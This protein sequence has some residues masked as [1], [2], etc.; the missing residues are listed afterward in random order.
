[1]KP[2]KVFKYLFNLKE[3]FCLIK[4]KPEG[5]ILN[6]IVSPGKDG[7]KAV[8]DW[9]TEILKVRTKSLPFKGRANQEIEKELKKLFNAETK[10][11]TG[12]KSKKKTVLVKQDKE[13]I[14][15][16]LNAL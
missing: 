2:E 5:V 7:F 15:S 11:L 12:F 13:K 1:M 6:L 16:A 3:F 4:F 10:I 14:L 8:F 9:E